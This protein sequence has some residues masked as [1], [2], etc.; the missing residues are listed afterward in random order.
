MNTADDQARISQVSARIVGQALRSTGTRILL[1]DIAEEFIGSLADKG[2]IRARIAPPARWLVAKV[3]RPGKNGKQSG[4]SADLGRLLTIWAKKINAEHAKD[5]LCHSATKGDTIH[6]F[7]S[8]TDFGEIREMVEGSRQC[9]LKTVEAFNAELWKYPAKVGSILGTLLAAT[10]TAIR[11]ARE[12]LRPIEKNVGPDLLA[13]MILSL[14]K[15]LDAKDAAEL[16]NSL[17]EFI[18][19]LHTGNYLLAKAGKPLFQIYLTSLLQEALPEIDPVLLKKAKI[20][21]AED[22]ESIAN[23][24][25]DA[26]IEN[27]DL[28]MEMISAYGSTKTPLIKGTARKIRLFEEVDRDQLADATAKGLSDLDTFEIAEVINSFLRT[29]NS[30]HAVRPNVFST[31]ATSIADSVD[32]QELKDT[33]QW[34]IPEFIEANRTLIEACMPVIIN[35]LCAVLNP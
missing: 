11:S 31:I 3:L 19:R 18:R 13:D 2:G 27:P 7:L 15:G 17:C 35:S 30:I 33:A 9:V 20:A 14:L 21:L 23:A 1:T 16:T 24:L 8:H 28:V 6:N 25:A 26:M 32:I 12:M 34:V 10:N 5:P 4:V 22:R 29:I